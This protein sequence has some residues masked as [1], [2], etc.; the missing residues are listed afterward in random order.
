MGGCYRAETDPRGG[1]ALAELR[2]MPVGLGPSGQPDG[3]ENFGEA[4][5][6]RMEKLANWVQMLLEDLLPA[7]GR[8]VSWMALTGTVTRQEAT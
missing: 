4:G 2:R 5:S 3:N 1:C 7:R 8:S 6:T